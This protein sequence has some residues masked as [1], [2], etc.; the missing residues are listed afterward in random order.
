VALLP[1]P[2]ALPC[3][4]DDG[5]AGGA[6][7]DA[8]AWK[9]AVREGGKGRRASGEA[10]S[11]SDLVA[12]H[13]FRLGIEQGS[14]VLARSRPLQPWKEDGREPERKTRTACRSVE[15]RDLISPVAIEPQVLWDAGLFSWD[16]DPMWQ[17]RAPVG[18]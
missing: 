3:D 12:D 9:A 13:H 8:I 1:A 5:E 6:T 16:A 17:M 10:L 14:H 11:L 18:F 15:I 4:R 2:A 7:E